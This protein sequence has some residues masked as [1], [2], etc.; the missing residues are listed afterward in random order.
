VPEHRHRIRVRYVESD[1]MGVAHHSAYVAWLEEARIEWLRTVGQSYRELET[2]GVLM[3][4][5]ELGVTYKRSF[6]FD[7]ELDLVTSAAVLGRTRVEFMTRFL[8]AGESEVRAEGRVVIAAVG[9]DG[10]PQRIPA[11]LVAILAG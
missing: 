8:L 7:D 2:A 10:R 5:I 3:P 11:A 4:V 1:Q 9:R 6:R